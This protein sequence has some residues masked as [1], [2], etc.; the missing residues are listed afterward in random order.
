MNLKPQV[1]EGGAGG[2]RKVAGGLQHEKAAQC[3]RL[4]AACPRGL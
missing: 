2:D 4:Q 3:A 1:A